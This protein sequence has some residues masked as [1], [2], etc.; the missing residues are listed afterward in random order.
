MKVEFSNY[1]N[2][3]IYGYAL[4]TTT[5]PFR[6]RALSIVTSLA[7]MHSPFVHTSHKITSHSPLIYPHLC[8]TSFMEGGENSR[9]MKVAGVDVL[10]YKNSSKFILRF[11][12][13]IN[14][15]VTTIPP[16]TASS[17]IHSLFTY[18]RVHSPFTIVILMVEMMAINK[19]EVTFFD[20]HFII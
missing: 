15:V 3:R 14:L 12:R 10:G 4:A 9:Q 13:I 11:C 2:Y 18:T 1:I 7:H 17:I 16:F 8:L 5:T 19:E 20:L 6:F